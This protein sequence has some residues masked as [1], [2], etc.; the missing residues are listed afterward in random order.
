MEEHRR[1]TAC[2]L[3]L[4]YSAGIYSKKKKSRVKKVWVKSWLLNKNKSCYKTLLNE[5]MLH[6]KEEFRRY[7]RINTATFEVCCYV[8]NKVT[9]KEI[10][11]ELRFV[12][13]GNR[14]V[15]VVV[16]FAQER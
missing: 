6:D 11:F 16:V 14:V 10:K 7:L 1:R 15:V 5:L 9:F 3:L 2:A 13:L 4:A 12:I 8:E